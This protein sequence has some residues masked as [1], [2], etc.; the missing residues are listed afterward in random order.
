[1]RGYGKTACSRN[2]FRLEHSQRPFKLSHCDFAIHRHWALPLAPKSSSNSCGYGNQLDLKIISRKNANFTPEH[3]IAIFWVTMR[4]E[5][6]RCAVF[7]Q[8]GKMAILRRLHIRASRARYRTQNALPFQELTANLGMIS[9]LRASQ[10]ELPPS[11]ICH[12][13]EVM[14]GF[15]A[16]KS[17]DHHN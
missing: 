12:T 13:P 10:F 14:K 11:H 15:R 2:F 6:F 5:V 1:M 17:Y 4:G 16:P 8:P 3:R 7:D 9:T